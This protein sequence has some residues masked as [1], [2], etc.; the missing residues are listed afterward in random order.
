MVKRCVFF[1]RDN[2]LY[3]RTIEIPW[4]KDNLELNKALYVKE[5]QKLVLPF[6]EP[7]IDVSTMSNNYTAKGM[8]TCFVKDSKGST[9]K[10][11]WNTLN[12]NIE[13]ELLPP[14]CHDL[15]Y[16]TS[17]TDKQVYFALSKGSFYDAFYNPDKGG[18]CN[19]KALAS[20]QLLYKQG[21][22]DYIEDMQRF[23]HWYFINCQFPNEW[24]AL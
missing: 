23:L 21:K 16:L 20:L 24:V 15:L 9:V 13:A 14:G 17:L 7:C 8:A 5:I 2:Q 11:I 3:K 6:M 18:T 4:D 22:V 10:E 12:S 1:I 19:A